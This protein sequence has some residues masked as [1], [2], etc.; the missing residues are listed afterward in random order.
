MSVK[1]EKQ[2]T[3]QIAQ[4]WNYTQCDIKS[5]R[6]F[7]SWGWYLWSDFELDPKNY[8]K[9]TLMQKSV[10]YNHMLWKSQMYHLLLKLN[11]RSITSEQMVYEY[12]FSRTLYF[13]NYF[14]LELHCVGNPYQFY[15]SKKLMT[16][17]GFLLCLLSSY[18]SWS[19]FWIFFKQKVL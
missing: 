7:Q 1:T 13:K 16:L 11:S 9:T 6:Q 2:K 12:A 15:H 19:I 8:G 17:H 10:D 14:I 5:N 4:V 3:T 18:L